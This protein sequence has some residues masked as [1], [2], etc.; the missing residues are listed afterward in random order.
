MERPRKG[1]Q[2][3]RVPLYEEH[4]K[5]AVAK[6]YLEGQFSYRQLGLKYNLSGATVRYFVR[7]YQDHFA[8][9]AIEPVVIPVSAVHE[10]LTGELALA[11][12]KVTAMEMLISNYEKEMGV[13]II[14]KS[15]TKP[16]VK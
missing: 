3:G 9:I 1:S 13:D 8:T 10:N 4:L 2:I 12:L 5:I 15:G 11:R 6:A 14:K 16:P 7:W